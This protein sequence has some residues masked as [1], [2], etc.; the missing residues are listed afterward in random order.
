[1]FGCWYIVLR[2]KTKQNPNQNKKLQ[3]LKVPAPIEKVV[4]ATA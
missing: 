4:N 1:M 2:M 3:D